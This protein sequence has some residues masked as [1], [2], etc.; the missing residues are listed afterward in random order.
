MTLTTRSANQSKNKIARLH[1]RVKKR[2]EELRK[3]K[4]KYDAAR[5]AY[6]RAEKL[7]RKTELNYF[8]LEADVDD[9][10]ADLKAMG[11]AHD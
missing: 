6:I 4:Q 7:L 3:A 11:T 2:R 9:L 10:Q 1:A 5:N 8:I